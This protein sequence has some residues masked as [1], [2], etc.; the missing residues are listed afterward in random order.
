[1]KRESVR[2]QAL[3]NEQ[4]RHRIGQG[5][6]VGSGVG[7]GAPALLFIAGESDP[8]DAESCWQMHSLVYATGRWRRRRVG[9]ALCSARVTRTWPASR[10]QEIRWSDTHGDAVA[11]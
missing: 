3:P 7:S 5:S 8:F 9:G 2:G 11:S 4:Q 1:M 6:G 10:I